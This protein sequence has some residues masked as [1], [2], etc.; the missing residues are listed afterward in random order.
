M[1]TNY[2]VIELR[3]TIALKKHEHLASLIDAIL[4]QTQ[5]GLCTYK[6]CKPYAEAIAQKNE[7]MDLCLPGG[8]SVLK[9]IGAL[10]NTDVASLENDMQQKTKPPMMAIIRENECIGCTKCIQ[11]CPVDAIIG[12][13]KLMHTVLT[14][15]CNGC[16]LCVEPCPVDCI[17]M[18]Q[19]P[20]KTEVE[21][22]ALADQSRQRYEKH[23]ARAT[24]N[25]TDD[26][27]LPVKKT[28][29]EMRADIQAILKRI[30][31]Q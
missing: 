7:R 18:I 1:P 17:D 21:K 30:K 16:E 9:K 25:K 19:L 5:C 10:C 28:R 24:Q 20:E 15:I 6:G 31:Q 29:E 4:P 14:D 2:D 13:S 23:V 12:A 26:A 22:K 27:D 8:V 11:A 3:M